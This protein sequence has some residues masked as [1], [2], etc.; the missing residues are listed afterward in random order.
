MNRIMIAG[1]HSGCGKTTITCGLL[2]VLKDMG[3]KLSAFKCGPDY[4]DPMFHSKILNV[5]SSNLDGFFT[6]KNTLNYLLKINSRDSDISVI[7][8][9]MGF[10]DGYGGKASAFD[11]SNDTATPVI[12]VIDC[13]GMSS[14]IGAVM[15]GYLTYK[16]Q[17][18]IVGFIFNRLPSSLENDIKKICSE[19]GTEYFGYIPKNND[20]RI[21]SRHLGLI[22]ADEIENLNCKLRII[23]EQIKKT[24][25]INKI[26]EA[27]EKANMVYCEIPKIPKLKNDKRVRVAVAYDR[28]F[29]F[30]YEDNLKLIVNMGGEIIFFSPLEDNKLPENIDGLILGGGYPELYAQK[31]SENMEMLE[32]IKNAADGNIPIIA[33]CGG[34]MYLH[35]SIKFLNGQEYAMAGVI[36]AVAFETSKLQR[37]GYAEL[38]SERDNLI[39]KKGEIIR[40]HEFHYWDSNCCGDCFTARKLNGNQWKCGYSTD[41]I[42][43]GFPHFYFYSKPSAA[44]S[45]LTKCMKY[46]SIY[47]KNK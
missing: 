35:K 8:G 26:I 27:S 41:N 20:F 23:S 34:F 29:C 10:Y 18:N 16:T 38:L 40:V 15:K 6:D 28:A 9:V 24:V 37:F 45:F 30:H 43:A 39:C 21:G 31:L 14:S 46:R 17:N 12:L 2:K 5:K 33:E 11:I 22:T 25:L 4:I 1:T 19:M 3:F 47:G 7:E 32:S 44:E 13:L 36:D 42:I